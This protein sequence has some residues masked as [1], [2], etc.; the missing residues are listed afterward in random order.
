MLRMDSQRFM[1]GF[2]GRR[3]LRHQGRADKGGK[4][5]GNLPRPKFFR[6]TKYAR[7][8]LPL[9]CREPETPQLGNLR[10]SHRR[11]FLCPSCTEV[12]N[13]VQLMSNILL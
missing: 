9:G 4:R 3:S 5:C 13:M 12:P 10:P 7:I 6:R 11:L 1:E 2:R 8:V